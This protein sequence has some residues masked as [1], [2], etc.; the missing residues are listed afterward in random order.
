V[1]GPVAFVS[2]WILGALLDDAGLSPIDDAISQ[3]AAV[4]SNT[5]MLMTAGLMTFGLGV[6]AFAV[7]ATSVLGR[8][9]ALA[10]AA[11]AA[12]TIAVAALP[13]GSFDAVD[14]LHGLA[15]GFGYITLVLAPIAARKPLRRMGRRRLA[16]AGVLASTIAAVSLTVSLTSAPTGVFQRLG[17]ASI[18][19]WIVAVAVQILREHL[20]SAVHDRTVP[21]GPGRGGAMPSTPSSGASRVHPSATTVRATEHAE[22]SARASAVRTCFFTGSR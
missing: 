12:S 17:I 13:L 16:A 8:R 2:A 21:P 22:P 5:R 3:L 6:G 9:T 19:I 20:P 10:L 18:D 15:A 11:T 14:S 7:A 1:I 4:D